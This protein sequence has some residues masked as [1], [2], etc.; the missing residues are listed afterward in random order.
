MA[1]SP[2]FSK[3]GAYAAAK[4]YSTDFESSCSKFGLAMLSSDDA[5]INL[6]SDLVANKSVTTQS[7]FNLLSVLSRNLSLPEINE[8]CEALSVPLMSKVDYDARVRQASTYTYPSGQAAAEPGLKRRREDPEEPRAAK[9]SRVSE[10]T[11]D[12]GEETESEPEVA[13]RPSNFRTITK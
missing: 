2:L 6:L 1:E 5:Q 8:R 13:A 7:Y 10:D 9:S 11:E 4:D 12:S 3:T